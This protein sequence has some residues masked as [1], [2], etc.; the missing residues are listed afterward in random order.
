MLNVTGC[1]PWGAL[2]NVIC[3]PVLGLRGRKEMITEGN[4]FGE[5]LVGE[6]IITEGNIFGESLTYTEI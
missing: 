6:K 2:V 4:L 3:V 1:P 5:S